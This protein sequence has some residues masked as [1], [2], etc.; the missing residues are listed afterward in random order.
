[1]VGV[2][3]VAGLILGPVA[4]AAQSASAAANSGSLSGTVV[5]TSHAPLANICVTAT[6]NQGRSAPSSTQTAA[7]GTY[8]ISGLDQNTYLINFTDCSSSP[9]Y[10]PQYYNGTVAGSYVSYDATW[11]SVSANATTSSVNATLTLAGSVSGTVTNTSSTP[12]ANICVYAWGAHGENTQVAGTATN[13]SGAYTISG[14]AADDYIVFFKSCGASSYGTEYYNAT[15]TGAPGYRGASNVVVGAGTTTTGINAEMSTAGSIAGTVTD[16]SSFGLGG[17]CVIATGNN[18]EVNTT[19]TA[20]DGTYTITGLAADHYNVEF[21]NQA[22]KGCGNSD[23]YGD[24]YYNNTA[25][26]A[27]SPSTATLIAISPGSAVV[28]INAMM[29]PGGAITGTITDVQGDPLT[30]ICAEAIGS[31]G[32]VV[33]TPVYHGFGQS[34]TY[35]ISNLYPDNYVVEFYDCSDNPQYPTQFFDGNVGGSPTAETATLLPVV[36]DGTVS[37]IDATMSLL[38]SQF[39]RFTSV[40]PPAAVIGQTYSVAASGGASGNPI[41][42]SIDA[43]SSP[44]SCSLNGTT[45]SFISVGT[46]IIDADQAGTTTYSAAAESRQKVLVVTALTVQQPLQVAFSGSEHHAVQLSVKGGSGNGSVTYSVTDGTATGCTITHSTLTAISAGTCIVT[47][48]KAASSTYAPVSSAPTTVTLSFSSVPWRVTGASGVLH[49]GKSSLI[50]LKGTNGFDQSS[51][52]SV[53][54]MTIT[55]LRRTAG[56][57]RLRVRVAAS[58]KPGVYPLVLKNTSGATTKVYIVMTRVRHSHATVGRLRLRR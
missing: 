34:S 40:A 56:S 45:V 25:A 53:H 21:A 43:A 22:I 54:G 18:G 29:S 33:G 47:A 14:L 19:T 42:Y 51:V 8:T 2:L 4:V 52:K 16:T 17:I 30:S 44:G 7:D 48:T 46:C 12:L 20:H 36:A 5:N 26:G 37:S 24:Q 31:N 50:T 13:A 27:P 58:V 1:M 57:L 10:A 38:T 39:I 9:T 15:A 23:N 32:Q 41:I 55:V 35:V 11:V 3:A 28:G 6:A 49:G